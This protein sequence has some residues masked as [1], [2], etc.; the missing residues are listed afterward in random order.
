MTTLTSQHDAVFG[1]ATGS[2]FAWRARRADGEVVT[3]TQVGPDADAIANQLRSDGLIVTAIRPAGLTIDFDQEAE[4]VR[5]TAGIRRIKRS[6]VAVFCQQLGVMLDTGV[7]LPEALE[8]IER[9]SRKREVAELV[10]AIQVEVCGGTPLSRSF[11]ARPRIFPPVVI[12]LVK[13]SEASGT[14]AL[15]LDRV[16]DYL[17]RELRTRRQVT[18]AL[19]YPAFMLGTA[20]MVVGFM[21]VVILPRFARIY[22]M[23]ATTLPGPT[24]FMIAM[25]DFLRED[26]MWWGPSLL[27]VALGFSL[28][29]R[30]VDGRKILDWVKL[31][32]PI[33]GPMT[34][35]LY[36]ARST[37]TMAT[38]LAGGVGLL[39]VIRICRGI[40]NNR[41]FD[42]LW[43]DMECRVRDGKPMSGAFA[44]SQHVP[45]DVASM[46]AS[47]ERSGRLSEVMEKVATRSDETLES[48]IK[49]ATSMI[50]PIL[51]VVMGIIVGSVA[52]ALLL[53]VFKM[54]SMV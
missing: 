47:G 2:T 37:R 41:S 14:M 45:P 8:A 20:F 27:A 21:L 24:Q 49:H 7:P 53:P 19:T 33:I 42:D 5:T 22:E 48:G 17:N 29:R 30:T 15:M 4:A 11:A 13:A 32:L 25:G 43:V 6:D 39:D 46:I 34:A 31:R 40:T 26:W 51:I 1:S 10:R 18:G 3:G 44:D 23:K 38:L 12:S 16:G 35:M 54:S 36:V 50:E 52:M 28:W 9:Q